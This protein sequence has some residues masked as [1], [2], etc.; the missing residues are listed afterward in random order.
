MAS[1]YPPSTVVQLDKLGHP[2]GFAVSGDGTLVVATLFS[3]GSMLSCQAQMADAR[4]GENGG[5]KVLWP[6]TVP[7]RVRSF[8]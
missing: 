2:D 5:P 1:G 3:G 7:S 6:R 4:Y 8:G